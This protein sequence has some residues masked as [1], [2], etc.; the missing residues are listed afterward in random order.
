MLWPYTKT[1]VP[2][3]AGYEFFAEMLKPPLVKLKVAVTTN[4]V[5]CTITPPLLK[6]TKTRRK[7]SLLILFIQNYT[8]SRQGKSLDLYLDAKKAPLRARLKD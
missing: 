7:P 4:S 2:A 1:L 8:L 6:K 5:P 3:E